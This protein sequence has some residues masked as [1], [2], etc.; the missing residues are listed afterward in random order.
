MD[1]KFIAGLLAGLLL[2]VAGLSFAQ[3]QTHP[4]FRINMSVDFW[5]GQVSLECLEG[6]S[7]RTRSY[8]CRPPSSDCPGGISEK[9]VGKPHEK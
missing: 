5:H 3:S 8:G 6:C 1:K 7:W 2:G 9:G 4:H